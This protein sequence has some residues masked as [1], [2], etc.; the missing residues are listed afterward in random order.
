MAKIYKRCDGKCSL[1]ERPYAN[2]KTLRYVVQ[3]E[4]GITIGE[5]ASLAEAYRFYNSL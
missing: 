4:Y 5:F 2:D 3:N 1:W